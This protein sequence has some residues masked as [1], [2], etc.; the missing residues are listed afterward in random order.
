MNKESVSHKKALLQWYKDH[1]NGM[2]KSQDFSCKLPYLYD[3]P[4]WPFVQ[5]WVDVAKQSEYADQPFYGAMVSN[6]LVELLGDVYD[7]VE[8]LLLE[9]KREILWHKLCRECKSANEIK[10]IWF[11]VA[12]YIRW[13]CYSDNMMNVLCYDEGIN[14]SNDIENIMKVFSEFMG[15]WTELLNNKVYDKVTELLNEKEFELPEIFCKNFESDFDDD[16]DDFDDFD[17]DKLEKI[18]SKLDILCHVTTFNQLHENLLDDG[19]YKRHEDLI[20]EIVNLLGRTASENINKSKLESMLQYIYPS[21]PFEDIEGVTSGNRIM[22]MLPTEFSYFA[23]ST[24]EILFYQRFATKQLQ[25]FSSYLKENKVSTQQASID[26]KGPI[27]IAIDTSGSMYGKPMEFV[28]WVVLKAYEIAE[29]T[30]RPLYVIDFSVNC[31]T[32][33]LS[34]KNAQEDLMSFLKGCI[35]GGSDGREMMEQILSQLDTEA[36]KYADALIVSDFEFSALDATLINRVE[37]AQKTGAKF[38]G[39]CINRFSNPDYDDLLDKVWRVSV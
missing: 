2:F 1:I 39:I 37:E 35:T 30:R 31:K 19:V 27:I 7:A 28:K 15:K 33:D 13:H 4:L 25:L 14:S 21:P 24:T 22:D 29:I 20:V 32:L 36:Y 23:D 11:D 16:F 12:C 38:Y 17:D 34:G 18:E 8:E 9:Y 3:Y 26:S 6:A 5:Y 10:T